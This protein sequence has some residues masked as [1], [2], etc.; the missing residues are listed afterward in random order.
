MSRVRLGADLHRGIGRT[1]ARG[2]IQVQHQHP[3]GPRA[4]VVDR[5]RTRLARRPAG[6]GRAY[7][8]GYVRPP[9]REIRT[10]AVPAIKDVT[11]CQA[12]S[13]AARERPSG[14]PGPAVATPG[15]SHGGNV[16][17]AVRPVSVATDVD[18]QFGIRACLA[19]EAGS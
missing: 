7:R 18:L 13:A 3:P 15:V 19:A 8:A 16:D 6:S 14:L 9:S 5:H 17:L 4:R 2:R 11:A 12:A 10:C 1:A